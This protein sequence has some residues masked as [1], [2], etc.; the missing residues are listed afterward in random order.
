MTRQ[1]KR[2]LY[3]GQ[4]LLNLIISR[5][6]LSQR[7]PVVSSSWKFPGQAR[8]HAPVVSRIPYTPMSSRVTRKLYVV[9]LCCCLM[10]HRLIPSSQF[11]VVIGVEP[12]NRLSHQLSSLTKSR[13]PTNFIPN[14]SSGYYVDLFDAQLTS[15]GRHLMANR[16]RRLLYKSNGNRGRTFAAFSRDVAQ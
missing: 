14:Y 7:T 13:G 10:I 1:Q 9:A 8:G 12:L 2:K 6:S 5:N 4:V 3:Y 16:L 11:C 15:P